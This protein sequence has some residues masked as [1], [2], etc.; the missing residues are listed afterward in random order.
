ML[1]K[2]KQ[3]HVRVREDFLFGKHFLELHEF[4][5]NLAM[6]QRPSLVDQSAD[7]ENFLLKQG[8]IKT[9]RGVFDCL[10]VFVALL[11]GQIVQVLWNL[12]LLSQVVTRVFQNLLPLVTHALKAATNGVHTGRKPPL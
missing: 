8:R 6:F 3:L 9:D 10:Y 5:L 12:H 11:F 7:L 2:D 1:S 4:G